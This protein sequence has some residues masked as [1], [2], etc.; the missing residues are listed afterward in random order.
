MQSINQHISSFN[1]LGLSQ[2]ILNS[3]NDAGYET[4]TPIQA[5]MIPAFLKGGDIL[6][7]AQTGTGKTAAFALPIIEKIDV[8]L[9]QPQA[10]ILAPTREL[11]LQ[12]CES[13]KKYGAKTPGLKTLA[14]YGGQDYNT[15]L[16]A[17]KKGTHIVVGT[18]GRVMDHLDRKTLKL[19]ALNI[20][21]LDE[22]D[23]M[24]RMGFKEDVE[25][26]LER[27]PENRQ[28][29][30]FSATIPDEIKSI[31]KRFLNSPQEITIKEKTATVANTRQRY[32][33]VPGR[34]KHSTLAMILEAE[35]F[36][37][38]LIFGRTRAITVEIAEKLAKQGFAATALNGDIAQNQREKIVEK[39]KSGQINIIVATDVA[40]RGLD[41][42]RISH[43][44]NYD[45][46]F[47][48]ETYVHRIG[49]TGRAGRSGEAI[50]FL[51]PREKFVLNKIERTTRQNI[52]PMT[53]PSV[54]Q[55]NSKRIEH[56]KE[57]IKTAISN[58][59]N[60]FYR[61][62]VEQFCA[63]SNSDPIEVAAATARLSQGKRP[64][65]I[66]SFDDFGHNGFKQVRNFSSDSG[67][68]FN[69]GKRSRRN[70]NDNEQEEG[71]EKYRIEVGK[72]HG[73]LPGHI[74]GAI[75]GESGMD[76]CNIGRIQLF[77]KFSTVDLP[78]NLPA[79]MIDKLKTA[80]I[81]KRQLEIT[82]DQG[83]AKQKKARKSK[84]GIS[85]KTVTAKGA[86]KSLKKSSR[87]A[88]RSK[89][90]LSN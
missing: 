88:D 59:E 69:R 42:E 66:E 65:L 49:R 4:P 22:A 40:A 83:P 60:D 51:S 44:I 56:F 48:A 72:D 54:E 36:D 30:L 2:P 16:R 25:W 11:A 67:N 18:P 39:L 15:Q 86:K 45:S 19:D 35:D 53:L 80:W 76:S 6:G 37:G 8:E 13:F 17:L 75:A 38:A 3:L 28:I 26:I 74:V 10:L 46:P 7:Q 24:L 89:Q 27:T 23:E 20:L 33:V 71:M 58:R 21:V 41:V 87:K 52:E 84:S 5:Q 55:I 57:K 81:C 9:K 1:D 61:K 14:I 43:V 78:E 50:L 32:L 79:K 47:D 68:K 29:A 31:S 63:E 70:R 82:L 62:L 73:V 64:L 85:K 77:D 34:Q 12:V 90:S